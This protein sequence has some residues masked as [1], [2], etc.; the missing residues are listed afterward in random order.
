MPEIQKSSQSGEMTRRF[1]EFL[2]MHAQ[3]AALFLGQVPHPGTGQPEVNLEV[4]RMF[5]D[6]LEMIEEKTR[7]NLSS[8]EA[9]LLSGTLTELRLAFVRASGGTIPTPAGSSPA[10]TAPSGGGS[11]ELEGSKP[12]SASEAQTAASE[13][14]E[15]RKKFTK[16]YG[17]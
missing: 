12:S 1:A 3:N 17:A 6:Q 7:G 13:Q 14:S 4:A 9:G 11:A 10:D 15:S 8:E 16:N 5:I 2:M